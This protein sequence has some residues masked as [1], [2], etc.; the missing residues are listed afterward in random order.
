M[1]KESE[2]LE[3][4]RR[5]RGFGLCDKYKVKWDGCKTK[6]DLVDIALDS[7][8]IDFIADSIAFGWGLSKEYLLSNFGEFANGFYQRIKGGYTSEMYVGAHGVVN[9][10]STLTLVAYCDDLEIH[11]PEHCVGQ[12]FICGGSKVRIENKGVVE[13]F[14]YGT[15]DVEYFEYLGADST[16]KTFRA[17]RWNNSTFDKR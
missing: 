12:I 6:K 3:M 9:L 17:S 8:G 16:H 7:Q 4:K 10:K 5:A 13:L 1:V 14:E 2:L 15:N 11:I